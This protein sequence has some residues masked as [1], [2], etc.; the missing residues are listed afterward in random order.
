MRP[1]IPAS[2]VFLVA[3]LFQAEAQTQA[4]VTLELHAT[5]NALDGPVELFDWYS[6]LRGAVAGRPL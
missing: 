6:S 4:T 3:G 2:F 1:T 5:S